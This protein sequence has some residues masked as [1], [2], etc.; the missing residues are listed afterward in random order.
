MRQLQRQFSVKLVACSHGKVIKRRI[1]RK[2]LQQRTVVNPAFAA[3][4]LTV[5]IVARHIQKSHVYTL[6]VIMIKHPF[7]L[8]HRIRINGLEC[9]HGQLLLP[10]HGK[11]S[12]TA[13]RNTG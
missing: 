11:H 9:T 2:Q 1:I 12:T 10:L 3:V 5:S 8:R 13:G 4:Q 6:P 7:A